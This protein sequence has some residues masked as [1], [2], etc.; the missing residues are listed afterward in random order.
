MLIDKA[1]SFYLHHILRKLTEYSYR[2]EWIRRGGIHKGFTIISQN[3]AGGIIYHNLHR[4]FTTPTIN[5]TIE[6]EDFVKF[7]EHL[8]YYLNLIPEAYTGGFQEGDSRKGYPQIRVGD[9]IV[10]CIHYPSCEEAIRKWESRKK[11][12]D[13]KNIFVIANTWDL[14]ENEEWICRLESTNYQ[15]AILTTNQKYRAK[16]NM[17]YIAGEFKRDGQNN[18]VP[19]PIGYMKNSSKMYF[20]EYFDFVEWLLQ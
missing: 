14:K 5:L 10:N 8:D 16:E 18:P 15:V 3:C 7:V 6:G 17:V 12:V 4:Q 2:N 11:R 13:Y 20:E 9:I 1:Y 19:N